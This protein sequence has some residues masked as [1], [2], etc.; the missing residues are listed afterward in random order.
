MANKKY[1][2]TCPAC[3]QTTETV[4]CK[5][6][7]SACTQR[8][9]K[10]VFSCPGCAETRL[11]QVLRGLCSRCHALESKR[12]FTCPVCRETRMTRILREM[13]ERCYDHRPQRSRRQRTKLASCL[14][15][16]K[17]RRAQFARGLC[18]T[19][20]LHWL[21]REPVFCP[22]CRQTKRDFLTRGLC[23][24]CYRRSLLRLQTC[25]SCAQT[26]RTQFGAIDGI[27]SACRSLQAARGAGT[28]AKQPIPQDQR[29]RGLLT[30]IAPLRRLW[31]INFMAE[32]WPAHS[33]KTRGGCMG[34]LVQFDR[35]LTLQTRVETGQWS[36]VSGDHVSSFL[37]QH[38]RFALT[39]TRAFFIWIAARKR[40]RRL[41]SFIPWRKSQF[42][43]R[44]TPHAAVLE[45]YR[46][47]TSTEAHP[48]QALAGLL[49]LVHCLRSFELRR[50]KV[51]DVRPPDEL[52]LGG[53]H[54]KLAPPVIAALARYEAWRSD[55]YSGP[56]DYLLVSA[57][58]RVS[59]RPISKQTLSR[60]TFLGTSPSGLR[61][62]AIRCLVQ[63][64]ADGLELAA[65][66]R[67]QLDA[68]QEYQFAFGQQ[69]D[70]EGQVGGNGL[71]SGE[72]HGDR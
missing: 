45:R 32:A 34:Q 9:A 47:W 13:C 61:Q 65:H 1:L 42:R 24:P 10:R 31:V 37:A 22:G 14:H 40:S 26:R 44:L 58:G 12:L 20:Y 5:G 43:T 55:T 71:G 2:F 6:L 53:R 35:F 30:Q 69:L 59:D 29:E 41:D 25:T 60:P 56:S 62:T 57:A 28:A 63:L 4:V 48:Q 46:Y 68:V 36:L 51:G 50:L 39:Q 17:S 52:E 21:G 54:I 15:C 11:T 23:Q 67:L 38:G 70:S 27:C 64:G 49:V 16:H 33:P 72:V 7:C 66:T 18:P 3:A 19:C 8:I